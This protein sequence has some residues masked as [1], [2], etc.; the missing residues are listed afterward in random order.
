M[1]TDTKKKRLDKDVFNAINNTLHKLF[2]GK[3]GS[4]KKELKERFEE[5]EETGIKRPFNRKPK[6]FDQADEEAKKTEAERIAKRKAWMA[7][8]AA[9]KKSVED[10]A[11]SVEDSAD[12]EIALIKKRKKGGR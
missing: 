4:L 10:S 11:K 12:E 3:G 2:V 6:T 9:K 8:K 7:K 1:S 5:E